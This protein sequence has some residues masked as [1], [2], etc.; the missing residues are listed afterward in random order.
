MN[1]P[2]R[3][4]RARP[5][6]GEAWREALPDAILAGG[7]VP[8]L[9][10]VALDHLGDPD[11][12]RVDLLT[13]RPVLVPRLATGHLRLTGADRVAFL[14]GL[15]SQDVAGLGEGEASDALL[16]DH[17]GQPQAGLTVHRRSEDLFLSVEDGAGPALRGVLEAHVVFDEVEVHDLDERLVSLT[18]AAGDGGALAAS[19]GAAWPGAD[20]VLSAVLEAPALGRVALGAATEHGR[21]L[22]RPWRAGDRWMAD[23]HLLAEDLMHAWVRW[24]E[25]GVRPVGERAWTAGR[26]AWGI[27]SALGEGRLGLPQETGLA[28]RVSTRKGCYLGQEIMARVEA[29][30]RLRRGLRQLRLQGPPPALGLARGWRI[31]DR[32]DRDVGVL[33]S[34]APAPD[35]DGW[36]ALA[37]VRHDAAPSDGW[38]ATAEGEAPRAGPAAVEVSLLPAA[39]A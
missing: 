33:G 14:H 20:Q 6:S 21:V 37:V 30:G 10:P 36:W 34:A 11:G 22:L 38:R 31:Q 8:W 17:R 4:A 2:D 23:V 28:R 27:P 7:A 39:D 18:L 1:D 29:R 5:G 16:L 19:A 26:V 32:G 15:L 9:D 12:E 25:A 24:A 35:G 13:G 3:G